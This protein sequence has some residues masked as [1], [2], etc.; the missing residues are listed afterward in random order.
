MFD[1][2]IC[3][4]CLFSLYIAAAYKCLIQLVVCSNSFTCGLTVY[5]LILGYKSEK[6]MLVD[7][8]LVEACP[9]TETKGGGWIEQTNFDEI[10]K[11]KWTTNRQLCTYVHKKARC[12][13]TDLTICPKATKDGPLNR[14]LNH[15]V[16]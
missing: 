14:C 5:K 9:N 8:L 1:I 3:C 7:L 6:Q 16:N 4:T 12:C 15:R 11:L 2:F 10:D 13:T